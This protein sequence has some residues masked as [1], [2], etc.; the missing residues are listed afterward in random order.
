MYAALNSIKIA[1]SHRDT[2]KTT[3]KNRITK[4]RKTDDFNY[5]ATDY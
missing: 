2:K 1:Q 5:P 3:P 4:A